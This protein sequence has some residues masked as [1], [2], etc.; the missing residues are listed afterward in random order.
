MKMYHFDPNDY[1]DCFFVMAASKEDAI[2]FVEKHLEDEEGYP[3]F[4]KWNVE[5]EEREKVIPD[6]RKPFKKFTIQE[7]EEGEVLP[8]EIN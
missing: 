4:G 2:K 3:T 6:F 8:M 5:S 1:G 7:F